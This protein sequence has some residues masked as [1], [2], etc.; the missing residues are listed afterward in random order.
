MLMKKPYNPKKEVEKT[1]EVLDK[2]K[3]QKAPPFLYTRIQAKL[4]EKSSSKPYGLKL[5]TF[6]WSV[7]GMCLLVFLNVASLWYYQSQ[8]NPLKYTSGDETQM[9][10]EDYSLDAP[11]Y[12][13]E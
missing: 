8:A 2:M 5:N 3:R 4:D 11:N 7:A 6:Q 9:L 10:I 13:N 1:L 12:Y